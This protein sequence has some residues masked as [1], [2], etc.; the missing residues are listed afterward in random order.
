MKQLLLF[1][2]LFF[3]VINFIVFVESA[4]EVYHGNRRYWIIEAD[5]KTHVALHVL[6]ERIKLI[7]PKDKTFPDLLSNIKLYS[8]TGNGKCQDK[9]NTLEFTLLID[10]ENFI[11]GFINATNI[12]RIEVV[13]AY[14]Y[15]M[16]PLIGVKYNYASPLI[17][18]NPVEIAVYGRMC[19]NSVPFEVYDKDKT[20]H[21]MELDVSGTFECQAFMELPSYMQIEDYILPDASRLV[22]NE[23]YAGNDETFWWKNGN[24]E[25]L[26]AGVE[27]DGSGNVRINISKSTKENPHFFRIGQNQPLPSLQFQFDTK[28]NGFKFGMFLNLQDPPEC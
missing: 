5:G 28:C 27:F 6:K 23:S 25:M 17:D 15:E 1:F 16:C 11:H 4:T 21:F 13:K 9:T 7:F 8:P 10:S 26:P 18:V 3:L 2:V 12:G 24:D 20:K 22:L 14:L 19:P